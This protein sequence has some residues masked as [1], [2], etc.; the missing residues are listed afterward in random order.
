M[1]ELKV[2]NEEMRTVREAM[3]EMGSLL[4]QLERGD[5]EKF[6][7]ARGGQMVAVMISPG[8]Y[9]IQISDDDAEALARFAANAHH[10][11]D[12]ED[13]ARLILRRLLDI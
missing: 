5:V 8:K 13:R 6:V 9:G 2:K 1:R 4:A 7:L 3:R 12:Q 10:T 11:P